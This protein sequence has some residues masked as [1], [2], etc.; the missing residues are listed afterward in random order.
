MRGA[1]ESKTK[2][3]RNLR[4]ASTDAEGTLWYR[5]RAR[6]LNGYKFVRQEPIGP[7][8]VDFICREQRLVIEVDGGQHADSQPD[9]I[10]DKWLVDHNYRVLRF[11]NNDVTSNLVGV[12]ETILTTLAEAPPHPDR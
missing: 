11:W 10:R 12:L 2:R 3:A 1:K 7:Y 4:S 8:T 9:A 6:R 5:L